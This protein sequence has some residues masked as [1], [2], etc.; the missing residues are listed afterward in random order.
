MGMFFELWFCVLGDRNYWSGRLLF[1]FVD[2]YNLKIKEIPRL[3]RG[4]CFKIRNT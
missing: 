4:F 3:T 1:S 2:F